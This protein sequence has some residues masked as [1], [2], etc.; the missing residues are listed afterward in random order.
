M[1]PANACDKGTDI[2]VP[3][4]PPATEGTN[5]SRKNRDKGSPYIKIYANRFFR[6]A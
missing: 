4:T 6:V 1:I 2:Q 5:K 3:I